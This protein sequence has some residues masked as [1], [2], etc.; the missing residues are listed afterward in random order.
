MYLK[1]LSP[2]KPRLLSLLKKAFIVGALCMSTA[3]YAQNGIN[4]VNDSEAN[5]S[6][7]L[8]SAA[9]GENAAVNVNLLGTEASKLQINYREGNAEDNYRIM[10]GLSDAKSMPD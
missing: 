1:R 2:K 6:K 9:K 3:T 10:G 5:F 7:A 8:F 4:I